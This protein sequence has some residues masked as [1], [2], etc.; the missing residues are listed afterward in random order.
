[1]SRVDE[2]SLD[3]FRQRTVDKLTKN[4]RNAVLKLLKVVSN[5]VKTYPHT[6][7]YL[8]VYLW[9]LIYL[10]N[11]LISFICTDSIAFFH[12]VPKLN[13]AQRVKRKPAQRKMH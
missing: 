8:Y 5:L 1:V 12:G 2:I 3:A 9:V 7:I 6:Y 4:V 11:C 13:K 10:D